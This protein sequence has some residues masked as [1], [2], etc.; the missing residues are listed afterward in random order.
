MHKPIIK[1][2]RTPLV[3]QH[4]SDTSCEVLKS[5]KLN[6]HDYSFNETCITDWLFHFQEIPG[7][8]KLDF[9]EDNIDGCFLG[10]GGNGFVLRYTK[11]NEC[12]AIKF[13]TNKKNKNKEVNIYKQIQELYK[14]PYSASF[15][16]PRYHQDGEIDFIGITLYYIVMDSADGTFKDLL[17]QIHKMN[18]REE[19]QE[20][21]KFMFRYLSETLSVLHSAN[22]IHRDIK[23][24]NILIKGEYPLLADFGMTGK[25]SEKCVRKK[26]PKY[27]PNPEFIEVCDDTLQIIDHK[28]DIFNLG[29][30]FFYFATGK[31]PIGKIDL[32]QELRAFDTDIGNMILSMLRYEKSNRMAS[33]SDII[34]SI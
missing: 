9:D 13:L 34:T 26:G 19:K 2:T 11:E 4:A 21:L 30:L 12:F 25:Q 5:I 31:Y 8:Y 17:C 18:D 33:L 32:E 7:E 20:K 27:W 6:N 16:I 1:T 22:Y 23:P 14:P 10:Q 15:R 24:E 3:R 28:S 29:C